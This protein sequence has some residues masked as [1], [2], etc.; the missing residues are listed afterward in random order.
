MPPSDTTS[1]QLLQQGLE[2]HRAGDLDGA[3]AS[4]RAALDID[5]DNSEALHLLGLTAHQQGRQS[6]A[7]QLIG[8]AAALDPGSAK[9]QNNLGLV[10]KALGDG[11]AARRHHQDRPD[12]RSPGRR[13][14]P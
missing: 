13:F 4:Y 11:A 14:R 8:R 5:A 6:D 1:S 10:H 2:K 3:A 12:A 9:I 7:L